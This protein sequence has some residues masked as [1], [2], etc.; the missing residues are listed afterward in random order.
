MSTAVNQIEA[1]SA[2]ATRAADGF[3]PDLEG[4]RGVAILLVVACHCG[5]ARCAGGFIGVD[6]FFVLSGYLIT[7]LLAT[8]HQ[9]TGRIDLRAFFARRIR[10]LLPAAV[11][12]FV[13]TGVA[14]LVLL[15]PEEIDLAARATIAAACYVSN[16]LFERT[17]AGLDPA[18]QL[19]HIQHHHCR[20]SSSWNPTH[21]R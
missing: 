14:A 15:A 5:I 13:L 6:V 16:V 19:P 17:A 18:G 12:V 9:T 10:R 2:R 1:R 3:R 21:A 4:L 20:R 7:G 8:E 11:L